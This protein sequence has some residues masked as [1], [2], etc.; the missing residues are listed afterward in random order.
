M[1]FE[2]ADSFTSRKMSAILNAQFKKKLA[3]Y[4][5]DKIL[6]ILMGKYLYFGRFNITRPY[7]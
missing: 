7:C 3:R 5:T 2:V 4:E 6:Y 1:Q